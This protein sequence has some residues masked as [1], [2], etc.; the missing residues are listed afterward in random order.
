MFN[1][2]VSA[3]CGVCGVQAVPSLTRWR[4]ATCVGCL[5]AP[6]CT[7]G[8]AHCAGGRARGGETRRVRVLVASG[9]LCKCDASVTAAGICASDNPSSEEKRWWWQCWCRQRALAA[10]PHPNDV[11][12]QQ[13]RIVPG[14]SGWRGWAWSWR[15]RDTRGP[16]HGYR[17]T[18]PASF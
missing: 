13:Q 8:P 9:W 4:P 2:I 16:Q 7:T 1:L 10:A 18:H 5:T 15:E 3:A 17:V 6:L 12:W 11:D 14:R